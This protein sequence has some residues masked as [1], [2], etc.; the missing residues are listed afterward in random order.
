MAPRNCCGGKWPQ[1]LLKNKM[2]VNFTLKT[3]VIAVV[4]AAVLITTAVISAVSLVMMRRDMKALIGDQ[5]FTM[6]KTIAIALDEGFTNRRMALRSLTQGI[7]PQA[8]HDRAAMQKYLDRHVGLTP[9]FFNFSVFDADGELQANFIDPTLA[10]RFNVAGREYMMRTLKTGKGVISEPLRSQLSG[11]AIVLMTEPLY[12]AKGKI[13]MVFVGS[14]DLQQDNFL[15]QF[16]D[17]R[18]GKSGYVFVLTTNG[19]IIEH[20][21]K[22]RIL[23]HANLIGGKSDGTDRALAGFE[24][25]MAGFNRTNQPALFSYKRMKTTNWIIGSIYLQ[26]EAFLSI[27]EM[28]N[29][30]L[31]VSATLALLAGWLAWL[32]MSRLMDPL[33]RL[34]GHIQQI[35]ADKTY[36]ALPQ[37]YRNDEI[38]DL[39][40]AFNSLMQERRDAE[41]ALDQARQ[42]LENMNQT[43]ERLALE[44]ELTGLANRRRLE[45]ALQDEF[46]R[47]TRHASWLALVMIDVDRFKQYNDQYG[48][49]AGDECLRRISHA[50]LQHKYR[51]GDLVARYGGEEIVVLLPAADEAGARAVAERIRQTVR[52][53]QIPHDGNESGVVT[54]S[55]GVSAVIPLRNRNTAE[56]L[57]RQADQALYLAKSDGRDCVRGSSES[58]PGA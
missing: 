18:V 10:G 48:H 11:R 26:E 17:T 30:V 25:S 37:N 7:P 27:S 22:S 52:Q 13:A 2:R 20:P 24:G 58:A 33:H 44:D 40:V 35:R 12:D 23:K 6:M 14:I 3:K 39:G 16:T 45:L 42:H 9:L 28:Q 51:P 32:V 46:N 38:G 50:I 19:I 5:Q 4:V 8:W 57:L 43:L 29:K 54:I 49:I 55:A 41:T 31:L 47:A 15:G 1:T 36:S 34:H 21:Q 56:E 53:L